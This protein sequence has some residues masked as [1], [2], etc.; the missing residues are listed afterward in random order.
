MRNKNLDFFS[1]ITETLANRSSLIG[2]IQLL[3]KK[4][5]KSALIIDA[6]GKVLISC[7][8][9][10]STSIKNKVVLPISL[11]QEIIWPR[12]AELI[13][14]GK[15]FDASLWPIRA[16]NTMGWV[17]VLSKLSEITP[18]QQDYIYMVSLAAQIELAKQKEIRE[19][20]IFL[21]NEFI[22]ELVFNNFSSINDMKKA[23]LHWNV[24]I[25]KKFLLMVI[26][27]VEENPVFDIGTLESEFENVLKKEY[28]F[29][30]IGDVLVLLKALDD[31]KS[32][33]TE[34][35]D[36]H[37]RLMA[38]L[39]IEIICGVGNPCENLDM[40][41]RGYQEAKV[42]LDLG[43]MMS[44]E[45]KGLFFFKELGAIRLFYNQRIQDLE[46]FCEEN[47]G[48]ILQYDNEDDG[49]LLHTLQCFLESDCN[50]NKCTN[51]LF[52]HINTLRYRLRLIEKLLN[53]DLES[54][55]SRFNLM[56]ALKALT[57]LKNIKMT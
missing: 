26:A 53:I 19:V 46:S 48:P 49:E 47:L 34:A 21:R 25:K 29:G 54:N 4:I 24:D 42:A 45:R 37:S 13:S 44:N 38:E 50:R 1:E 6:F 2:L 14:G 27:T 31:Q 41:Y 23:C 33:Y 11:K 3:N 43:K 32:W 9:V 52:I 40:V 17:A 39:P 16:V 28:T 57:I 7:F 51:K 22:R 10:E 8:N 35:I 20:D 30:Q 56:A 15:K 36:I 5:N 18:L 12:E 55:E